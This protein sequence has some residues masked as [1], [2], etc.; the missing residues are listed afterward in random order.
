MERTSGSPRAT[1][2]MVEQ[3][4]LGI[5]EARALGQISDDGNLRLV[6]E[7]QQLHGHRLEGEHRSGDQDRRDADGDQEAPRRRRLRMTGWPS[8]CRARRACLRHGRAWSARPRVAPGAKRTIS[9][10]AMMTATKKEKIIAAE[11]LIG[12]GAM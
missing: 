4:V 7:R 9:H 8:A 10:G 2:A 3:R 1:S 11:A 5:L 6:V 12:I